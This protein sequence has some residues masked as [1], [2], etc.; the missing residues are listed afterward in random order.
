MTGDLAA[1]TSLPNPVTLNSEEFI[2]AIAEELKA[3]LA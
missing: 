2:K 3:Q 1:I